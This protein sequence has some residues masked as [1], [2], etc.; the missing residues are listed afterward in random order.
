M[1]VLTRFRAV[2]AHLR[3]RLLFSLLCAL[4]LLK[5]LAKEE[6]QPSSSATIIYLFPTDFGHFGAYTR[7]L[8][9]LNFCD[10]IH[11]S[12]YALDRLGIMYGFHLSSELIRTCYAGIFPPSRKPNAIL[13]KGLLYISLT[14]V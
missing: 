7:D 4:E 11:V 1:G 6:L 8:F 9:T 2:H 5:L 14:V 12:S 13:T 3:W 10:N